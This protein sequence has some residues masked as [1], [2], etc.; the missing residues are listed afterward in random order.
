MLLA[1]PHLPWS[2]LFSWY[3]A[4]IT[5]PGIDA[6]GAFVASTHINPSISSDRNA[7]VKNVFF[8]TIMLPLYQVIRTS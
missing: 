2:D 3:E 5:A 8:N 1:N 4:Q 6:Y 7:S